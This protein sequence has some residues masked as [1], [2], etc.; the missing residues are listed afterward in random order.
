MTS[1]RQALVRG[2]LDWAL[3]LYALTVVPRAPNLCAF[4]RVSSN[5]DRA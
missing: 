3:G 1:E 2:V 5:L 4:A